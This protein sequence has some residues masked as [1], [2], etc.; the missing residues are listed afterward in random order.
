MKNIELTNLTQLDYPITEAMNT[1]CTNL[2]FSGRSVKK[3]LVTSCRAGEGK[4]FVSVNMAR[5]LAGDGKNVVVVDADLRRSS[6]LATYTKDRKMRGLAHYLAEQAEW[7]SIVHQ[8][9]V[10]GFY[11]VFN[12]Q[13]VV[14]PHALLSTPRLGELLAQLERTFDFVVVDSPPIGLVVDASEIAKACDGVVL[15][16]TNNTI[17]KK[18]IG[19]ALAQI[20]RTGCPL[21]GSVMNKVTFET[22]AAK[23]HYYKQYYSHYKSGYYGENKR[24]K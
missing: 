12:G 18:E 5:A 19:D 11:I 15:V 9:S 17:P 23:K 10:D 16:V 1:L 6:M 20:E 13:S 8:T 21:L 4:S 22:H 24:K 3:V 14:N 2:S 7:E